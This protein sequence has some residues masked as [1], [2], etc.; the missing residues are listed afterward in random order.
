MSYREYGPVRRRSKRRVIANGEIGIFVADATEPSVPRAKAEPLCSSDPEPPRVVRV[1]R[2]NE[3]AGQ[4]L[5]H[6]VLAEVRSI[7][8]KEAVFRAKPKEACPVL[9]DAVYIEISESFD[10]APEGVPLSR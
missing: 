1:K 2:P 3:S 8:T 5:S 6:S 7:V 10:I 4:A 9:R